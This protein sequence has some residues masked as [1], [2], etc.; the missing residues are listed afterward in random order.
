MTTGSAAG[1]IDVE[2]LDVSYGSLRALQDV[3][4]QVHAG[5]VVGVVGPNG[6]GKSTLVRTI[7][8][9]QVPQRGRV[10]VGGVPGRPAP[11][12]LAYV[13]Q[14]ATPDPL[15]PAVV[16]EVVWMGRYPHLGLWRRPATADR[17]AVEQALARTGLL[18]L[19]RRSVSALSGGQQR[20]V[21]IAR[22]L[23]LGADFVLLDEPFA[24][25]DGPTEHDLR[26]VI[27]QLAADGAGVLLVDHDLGAVA[28]DCDQ[29]ILLRRTVQAVGP[30]AEVLRPTVV[31]A[32]YGM[33]VPAGSSD[34]EEG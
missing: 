15:F 19:R 20:R 29:V 25:L 26:A 4:L 5:Q 24:G 33:R 21:A 28:Q 12:R 30:P 8:G 13:A 6:G 11:R 31:A 22:A 7:M 32:A 9:L 14:Q 1:R 18:G 16:E 17:A 3:S 34:R 10:L 23:A 27:A 2:E